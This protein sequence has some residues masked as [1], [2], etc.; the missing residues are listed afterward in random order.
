MHALK[1]WLTHPWT[2]RGAQFAIGVIFVVAGLAKVGD[3]KSFADQIHNFRLSPVAL[4]NLIA[5]T[6]PW[7]ELVC[8]LA[9]IARLWTVAAARLILGMMLVFTLAVGLAV[10][11]GLDIECGCFGTADASTVGISKLLENFGMILLAWVAALR[12]GSARAAQVDLAH[13]PRSRSGVPTRQ[14]T[15]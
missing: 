2:V 4:E 9:L 7:V 11:R 5:I 14:E 3:P 6:L 8:G 12:P 15:P 1:A 10:V 13:M